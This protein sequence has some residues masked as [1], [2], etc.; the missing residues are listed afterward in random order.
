MRKLS[1]LAISALALTSTAAVAQTPSPKPSGAAADNVVLAASDAFGERIGIEQVGLY[2]EG[3]SRGFSLANTGAYRIDGSYYAPAGGGGL[4]E[5]II[6]GVSVRL[7]VSA[8]RLDFPSP[9]GVVNYRLRSAPAG[10]RL[11]ASFGDRHFGSFFGELNGSSVAPDGRAGVVGGLFVQPDIHRPDGG[12]GE[13]YYAG[14]VAFWQPTGALRLRGYAGYRQVDVDGSFTFAANAEALA[15]TPRQRTLY[16]PGWS[17]TVGDDL[18][19]GGIV[20]YAPGADVR[21][22]ASTFY[23]EGRPDFNDTTLL[24]VR[25]DGDA[26]ATQIRIGDRRFTSLASELRTSA[27]FRIDG[28]SHTLGAGLR[29][30]NGRARTIG[31]TSFNL[32]V[33]DLD[34]P[35]FGPE[36][37]FFDSGA[38]TIDQVDQLTGSLNYAALIGETLEVRGGLHLTRYEKTVTAPTGSVTDRSEDNLLYNLSASYI[39]D[40]RTTFFASY[41]KGLEEAGV[42]PQTA[43]NRG[44][45]LPPVLAEQY[46]LGFRRALTQDLSLI[47]AVFDISKPTPGLRSD[48]VYALV[49]TVRHRGAELSLNGRL[50]DGTSFVAG[51]VAMEP[52]ISGELVDA[53]RVGTR[54]AG[55]SPLIAFVSL[56]QRLPIAGLSMDARVSYLDARPA[57]T[58]NTLETPAFVTVDVGG[59]YSF[60][61]GRYPAVLRATLANVFDQSE[62]VAGSGGTMNRT[63]PRLLRFTLSVPLM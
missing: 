12:E 15:A 60:A 49:G 50:G 62:W 17:Q 38:R 54:P 8:A 47:G 37:A 34:D 31:G 40:P 25:P 9:S 57:N 7:G 29:H 36:P 5:P 19:I 53:G 26:A 30:R 45:I 32:G 10:N 63:T 46:E 4:I 3:Q 56:D 23:A 1:L 22:T 18:S 16:A 2:S 33:I 14:G 27:Q 58:L 41:V 44:E 21:I 6:G 55:V 28:V 42:A 59:R 20:D 39:H 24:S 13:L 48:G 51:A 43:S 35:R 61:L 11:T 52:R